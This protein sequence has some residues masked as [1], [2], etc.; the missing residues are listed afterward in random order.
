MG[1]ASRFRQ[2]E[3]RAREDGVDLHDLDDSDWQHDGRQPNL[4]LGPQVLVKTGRGPH[5]IA[6]PRRHI[7]AFVSPAPGRGSCHP[8]HSTSKQRQPDHDAPDRGRPHRGVCG[9]VA[10]AVYGQVAQDASSRRPGER[11]LR[12]ERGA[13][14]ADLRPRTGDCR[15]SDAR[16]ASNSRHASSATSSRESSSTSSFR[17]GSPRL[18]RRCVGADPDLQTVG[19]A[20]PQT[21]A[22]TQAHGV[23]EPQPSHGPTPSPK[24]TPTPH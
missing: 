24:P 12:A 7:A 9:L 21:N 10:F 20:D 16:L 2:L 11:P 18:D 4:E 15:R 6:A 3:A 5:P 1:F 22:D 23:A 14:P 13:D 17:R 8:F 19:V